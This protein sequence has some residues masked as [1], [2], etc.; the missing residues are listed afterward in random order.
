MPIAPEKLHVLL[1][2]SID[3]ALWAY[4]LRDERLIFANR[5]FRNLLGAGESDGDLTTWWRQVSW[6]L[7]EVKVND[8]SA[9]P[10]NHFYYV[11]S[12]DGQKLVRETRSY[13]PEDGGIVFGRVEETD[14]ATDQSLSEMWS[15]LNMIMEGSLDM[16][17]LVSKEGEF[18]HISKACERLL[19]Y[20]QQELIGR[21]F[22]EF[23]SKED[24]KK[25]KEEDKYITT[26]GSTTNFVNHY[27][28]KDGSLIPLVW[29]S[30]WSEK[31]QLVVAIARDGRQMEA[32]DAQLQ[33]QTD[34]LRGISR[35]IPGA[36]FQFVTS[37]AGRPELVYMSE[38]IRQMLGRPAES[39]MEPR[40]LNLGYIHADDLEGVKKELSAAISRKKEL[41]I[42]YR[43]L[44]LNT[45]R[46]KWVK[47][48][49]VP[50][51]NPDQSVT[52]SG[53]LV[54]ID[55]SEK[56][57]RQLLD[58]ERK[59]RFLIDSMSDG[60]LIV[61]AKR[62]VL[63]TNDAGHRIHG[64]QKGQIV[65]QAAFDK[66]RITNAR[67]GL[68]VRFSDW[69]GEIKKENKVYRDWE[70]EVENLD[71]KRTFNLLMTA[72]P[73]LNDRK[74]REGF[75]VILKD[76]TAVRQIDNRVRAY[77]ERLNHILHNFSDGFF[78]LDKE[79][80]ILDCN[81]KAEFILGY[82][83]K[84]LIGKTI[85]DI[86]PA[87]DRAA[88][89]SIKEYERALAQ[90]KSV[91]FIDHSPSS[92]IWFEVNAYP[93][94]EQLTVFFKDI[95]DR[96]IQRSLIE[97]EKDIW[98]K[99]TENPTREL[100][101]DVLR[102][103]QKINPRMTCALYMKAGS[104]T[105]VDVLFAPG[106]EKK[107]ADQ[108]MQFLSPAFDQFIRKT[109]KKRNNWAV[110]PLAKL[111]MD[112]IISASKTGVPLKSVY[113]YPIY[114]P[115]A[116]L[117]G[118]LFIFRRLTT[119][120]SPADI[121]IAERATSVIANLSERIEGLRK[122]Q[123]INERFRLA[124]MATMDV[125]WDRDLLEDRMYWSD[126]VRTLLGYPANEQLQSPGW[127]FSKIHPDDVER[128]KA[129]LS[130]FFDSGEEHWNSQ[131]R[132]LDGSGNYRYIFD[133][134]HVI[135]EKSKPV[136]FI[137]AMQDITQI[138]EHEMMIMDQNKKL[139][140]IAWLHSHKVR[141]PVASIMGL[142]DLIVR[143]KLISDS[144]SQVIEYLN[145]STR[146]LDDV[147]REVVGLA[148]E[149]DKRLRP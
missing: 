70:F 52:W 59:L 126:A 13:T 33:H 34:Q 92:N 104:A 112:T 135:R 37:P 98:K 145:R 89:K 142:V 63:L 21:R 102:S 3:L 25:T 4:S 55:Q 14:E 9:F 79:L 31:D 30:T 68:P 49:A 131:Y 99:S 110:H 86:T 107:D 10:E 146:M 134:G 73:L 132:L 140:E 16:I 41:K 19:G 80:T 75:I 38:S 128:V 143:N 81:P 137:G 1:S 40:Q 106:L 51:E 42:K 36:L 111:G 116:E 122:I 95:T 113:T 138:K 23:V 124:T 60:V 144:D 48:Q 115:E 127:L 58:K 72:E 61:D 17:C 67:S 129:E 117:K 6:E 149:V 148:S 39:F 50:V 74:E 66:I 103:L 93:Y 32:H 118:A 53:T 96:R 64:L 123:F 2:N 35:I 76:I 18:I 147:I 65:D 26:G 119:I 114:Y 11:R 43:T 100:Y 77:A 120:P 125:V 88:M 69:I 84:E 141:S 109:V 85:Y 46:Y 108:L 91:Q 56:A 5:A 105:D 133:R 97:L 15:H 7:P 101:R 94:K 29:S 27:V 82:T 71:S 44:D 57:V 12:A 22:I 136:R 90:N 45:N 8:T 78:T 28:R 83:R 139:M 62:K 20:T 54:D 121:E 130:A 47:A 24:R 87:E